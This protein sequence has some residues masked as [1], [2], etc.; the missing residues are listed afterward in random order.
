MAVIDEDVFAKTTVHFHLV[1]P[2][3]CK[4]NDAK[5]E[6][7]LASSTQQIPGTLPSQDGRGQ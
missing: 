4:A 5:T 2:D 7:T 3:Y 6:Q 1:M